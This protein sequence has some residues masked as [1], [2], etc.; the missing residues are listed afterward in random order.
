[1]TNFHDIAFP[2]GIA[3]GAS[4]GPER[5]TDIV[6]LVSGHEERNT[7]W[8]DSRRRFNA[9]YG[10]RS[11]DDVHALIEFFEARQGRLYAFRF[12]DPADWKS[13]A[14]SQTPAASDQLLS[15]AADNP[16]KYPLVKTYQSGGKTYIRRITKPQAD[17][18][19]IAVGGAA[20]NKDEHYTLDPATGIVEFMSAHIPTAG[21]EVRAGFLFDVPVRF[22]S[23]YLAIN[24]SAFEAGEVPDIPLIEVKQDT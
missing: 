16:A 10:L 7:P 11:L 5:K 6:A 3:L 20:Q 23:D 22:D 9:G 4:G 18:V 8:R 19:K 14:P 2:A 21:Q 17:S 13:C 15:A 12:R 1:M 24:F